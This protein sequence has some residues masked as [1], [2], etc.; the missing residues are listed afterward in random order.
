MRRLVTLISTAAVIALA[1]PALAEP[2]GDD[3]GFLEALK[4]AGIT[5]QSSDSAVANAKAVCG[6]LDDGK[7]APEI[8][9]QLQQS[10]PGFSQRDAAKFV[11]LA[12][13]AYC[14]KYMQG[15]GDNK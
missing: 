12:S 15:G 14:P 2:S 5:Y 4:N 8:V 6:L 3:A 9:A 1:A 13:V 11:A 7:G 10:N